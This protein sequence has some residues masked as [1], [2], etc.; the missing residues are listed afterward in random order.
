MPIK[1]LQCHENTGVSEKKRIATQLRCLQKPPAAAS[2]E[3]HATAGVAAVG[4]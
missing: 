3:R 4:G 1:Y 2:A